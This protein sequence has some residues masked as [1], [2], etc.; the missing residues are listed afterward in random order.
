VAARAAGLVLLGGVLAGCGAPSPAFRARF[1][2]EELRFDFE[3]QGIRSGASPRVREIPPGQGP[4]D[5]MLGL[6]PGPGTVVWLYHFED[7]GTPLKDEDRAFSLALALEDLRPGAVDFPSERAAAVFFCDNWG[8][9]FRAAEARA[10]EGR[11]AVR[12]AGERVVAGDL[13]LVLEGYKQRPDGSREP[14]RLRL[15]G[16]F[17]ASR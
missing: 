2:G 1:E 6:E 3:V 14:F 12:E 13:D 16:R 10:V 5:R 15:E 17:R 4:S 9:G 8:R 11:L 7:D